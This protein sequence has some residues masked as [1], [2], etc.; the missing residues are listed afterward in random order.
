MPNIGVSYPSVNKFHYFTIKCTILK[1][2]YEVLQPAAGH[3]FLV[4]IFG[5]RAFTA[6]YHFHPEY[7]LTL[8]TEGRGKRYVGNHMAD[9]NAGDLVLI[10][11]H[12][13]HCWKLESAGKDRPPPRPAGAIVIQFAP[14]FLGSGFFSKAELAPIH[15]LLQNSGCGIQFPQL[16]ITD[17]EERIRSLAVT[18]ADFRRL[19]ILLEILQELALS[20]NSILLDTRRIT[21]ELPPI[22]RERIHPI[23]AHLVEN[24]R[25]EISLANAASVIGMT[26]NAFCRYFK[27]ITRKTYMETV[28]EYRLN[29]A[30]QQ[31]VQTSQSISDICFDSGFSDISHFYKM[32]RSRMQMSPLNYRRK[33]MQGTTGN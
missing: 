17:I 6:P 10:G 32:F 8:I 16:P 27:K 2:S 18:T 15:Q 5:E 26:P 28:I 22:D 30:T 31:L 14:D 29:Y 11:P 25:G 20:R 24:F 19:I 3:S 4:K 12:L 1:A 33:F 21:A 13:P 7:E 23:F 9:F